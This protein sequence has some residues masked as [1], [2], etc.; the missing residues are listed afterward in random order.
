MVDIFSLAL[1]YTLR[2]FAGNSATEIKISAWL[3]AFSLF[4]ILALAFLKRCAEMDIT[5]NNIITKIKRRGYI[6]NEKPI[7]QTIRIASS[8]RV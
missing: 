5:D 4:F 1:L 7:L 3:F 6:S 2:I 8:S